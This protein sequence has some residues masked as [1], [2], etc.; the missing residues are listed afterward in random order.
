MSLFSSLSKVSR[1]RKHALFMACMSPS[2][3]T[4]I[5]DVGAEINPAGDKTLQLID[6]YRWKGQITAANLSAEHVESIRDH[7]PQVQAAVADA[8]ALAWPDK[9]FDVVYSNA[10][11]EHVGDLDEQRKMASKIIWVGKRWSVTTPNRW[12]PFE[13]HLRLPSFGD[14]PDDGER[15]AELLSPQQ[16]YSC[17]GD[18]HGRNAGRGW[19]R[20]M[21]ASL[22]RR[23]CR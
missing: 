7:Y 8:R 9:Y 14:S 19:R 15:A 11:I 22:G 13:F 5:L 23:K 3:Q 12:Y 2:P 18:V 6:A 21:L 20:L 4:R 17:E 10:V 1:R 16:D